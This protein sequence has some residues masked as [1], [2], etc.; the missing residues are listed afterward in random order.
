VEKNLKGN[1][2]VCYEIISMEP[3]I[4][5]SDLAKKMGVWARTARDITRRL[6][7]KGI[8]KKSGYDQRRVYVCGQKRNMRIN[9]YEVVK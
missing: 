4:L 8:I 1:E 3:G 7:K 9:K 6:T 5:T 2:A